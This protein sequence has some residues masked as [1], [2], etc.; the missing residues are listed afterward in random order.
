MSRLR[1]N[2]V[3]RLRKIGVEDRPWPGRGDEFSSLF[4]RDTEFAHF[5]SDGELDLRLTKRMIKSEALVHPR[6]SRVHPN[7]SPNSQWI[8]VRFT[9][10]ADLDELVRL[11]KL[12]IEQL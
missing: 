2:L 8:E 3:E 10:A 11:V 1:R 5:H 7:R 9:R 12:A 4:Y 6:D